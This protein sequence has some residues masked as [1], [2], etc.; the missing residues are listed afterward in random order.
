MKTLISIFAML[1][2]FSSTTFSQWTTLSPSGSCTARHE[3]GFV[4][5]GDDLYLVGGRGIKPVEKYSIKENSWTAMIPTPLEMN[6]I[7][8]VSFD[9]KIYVVGG[10]V[11]KYPKEQPLTHVY[12]FDPK[13]NSWTKDIEIPENR[14]RGGAGVT[15]YNDKIYIVNGITLGHTSGTCA[16]FDVYD[17]KDKT[18]KSLPDAPSIRD[19]SSA[20][21]VKGKLIALGGR[22]TS[23]HK[24]DNFA[25]FFATTTSQVDYF[26]FK[27]EKWNTYKSELPAPGA[28]G[29]AVTLKGKVYFVGG[30]TGEKPANNHMYAFDPKKDIW[31]KKSFLNRG[32]HG[33]NAVL[34]KGK[35]YMAA[36]SGNRGGGPELNSIEVYSE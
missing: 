25:A 23:Y 12:I 24:P 3:C 28:G 31:T 16:M 34:S 14:R 15:I 29:G 1:V 2:G 18:W 19:H 26:D 22:N 20:V 36:G 7:T 27:T 30:E 32:R 8:P 33:T 35:I 5:H 9:G 11:G 13:S 21:I 10:L 6:H 17:P 4:A